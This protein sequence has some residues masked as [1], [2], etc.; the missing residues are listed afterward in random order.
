M[1]F[2]SM[3]IAQSFDVFLITYPIIFK[4]IL[5]SLVIAIPTSLFVL[6]ISSLFKQARF[7][8]ITWY[9]ML[10]V[11]LAI[12]PFFTYEMKSDNLAVLCNIPA[13]Y[14]NLII[15]IFDIPG[16]FGGDINI[17]KLNPASNVTAQFS[18]VS[19]SILSAIAYFVLLRKI[20]APLKV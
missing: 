17:K 19:L 7:P 11:G 3:G 15:H 6:M 2:L 18:F 12:S 13:N 8:M 16:S 14:K 10:L 1:Y 5:A 4:I 9:F 20:K